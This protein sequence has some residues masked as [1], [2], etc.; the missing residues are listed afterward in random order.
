MATRFKWLD[1]LKTMAIFLIIAG[2]C[3]VPGAK[4][5]YVFSVPCFFIISGF[6]SKKESSSSVFWTKM[7]WNLILPMFLF[8]LITLFLHSMFQFALG[9]FQWSFVWH[10]IIRAIAGFISVGLWRMWFVYTLILCKILYQYIPER[11]IYL[12]LLNVLFLLVTWWLN[13][14]LKSQIFE[15]ANLNVLLAMPFFSIGVLFHP[16]KSLANNLSIKTILLVFVVDVLFVYIS[17]VYNDQVMLYRCSYGSNLFLC[18][19]G[20]VAG[21]LVLYSISLLT[22][23]LFDKL[24]GI[25]GGGTLIILALHF[26]I[27]TLIQRIL[28]ISG[29]LLYVESLIVLLVCIPIIL[30]TKK[31][32][33]VLYGKYRVQK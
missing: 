12:F 5:I 29:L 19:I 14:S 11:K 28:S 26:E 20:G 17:G 15:N 24:S 16:F 31:Y 33:P 23:D 13:T 32:T 27:I 6:L 1:T 22:Q 3:D 4:Y 25:V 8:V 10:S 30:F 18:I 21:T 2:H 9:Q 7:W